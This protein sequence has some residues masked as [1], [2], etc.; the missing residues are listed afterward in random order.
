MKSK[1][2]S[3]FSR[4]CVTVPSDVIALIDSKARQESRSRS[5]QIAHVLKGVVCSST[6]TKPANEVTR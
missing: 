1:L 2:K 6:K 3:E 4:V 5:A